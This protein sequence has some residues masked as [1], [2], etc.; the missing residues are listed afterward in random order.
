MAFG[1]RPSRSVH[2]PYLA[3]ACDMAVRIGDS[4]VGHPLRLIALRRKTCVIH[5]KCVTI[6]IALYA[7]L[8][9]GGCVLDKYHPLYA[10]QFHL[11][12][13]NLLKSGVFLD[14]V[15]FRVNYKVDGLRNP[16]LFNNYN[17][18]KLISNGTK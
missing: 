5:D 14:F 6:V 4:C 18:V 11:T 8:F 12:E 15:Y 13:K 2:N 10:S 1:Y 7:S 3:I 9:D 17:R 16:F